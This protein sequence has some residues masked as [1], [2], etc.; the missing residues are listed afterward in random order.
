MN[1]QKLLNNQNAGVYAMNLSRS[2]SPGTAKW[3]VKWISK[4]L[5]SN[6]KLPLVEGIRCNQWVAG[7]ENYTSDE[8]S[9]RAEM[10]LYQAGWSYYNLFHHYYQSEKLMNLVVFSPEFEEIIQRSQEKRHGIIVAGVHLSNFDL[11]AQAAALRG[12]KAFVLSVPDPDKAIQWQHDLR[13]QSGLEIMDANLSNL[14]L[15]IRKLQDG[16]TVVTGI[17]RPVPNPKM[18]PLFFGRPAHLAIHYVQLALRAKVPVIVMGAIMKEDGLY[19]IHSSGEILMKPHADRHIELD[20]NAE[21]ILEVAQ[22]IIG[23]ALEQWLVFQPVWPESFPNI[24]ND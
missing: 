6:K 11:V 1:I 19:H 22:A 4:W 5:A 16:E 24:P 10:V 9:Q 23:Q 20:T 2:L 21:R 17:D 14:R 18:R 8:L 7:G 3:V 15:A 12:L 13:R